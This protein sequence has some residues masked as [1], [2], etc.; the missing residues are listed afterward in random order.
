MT[1]EEE[2][3]G[4]AVVLEAGTRG[5]GATDM[6]EGHGQGGETEGARVQGSGLMGSAGSAVRRAI[7]GFSVPLSPRDG[8]LGTGTRV[9]GVQAWS[10]VTGVMGKRIAG[11]RREAA[12][13]FTM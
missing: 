9:Q 10:Q 4:G 5:G 13:S 1:T 7:L 11:R 8:P 12:D 6:E 2:G 3:G